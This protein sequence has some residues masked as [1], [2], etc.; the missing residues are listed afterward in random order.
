[1]QRLSTVYWYV[2]W[3]SGSRSAT[4]RSMDGN[5]LH[6]NL[7]L[8]C[9]KTVREAGPRYSPA[10]AHGSPN[11]K[12]TELTQ[13]LSGA[14]LSEQFRDRLRAFADLIAVAPPGRSTGARKANAD[15]RRQNVIADALQSAAGSLDLDAACN[16]LTDAESEL[17]IALDSLSADR[18][19]LQ[20]RKQKLEEDGSESPSGE[21]YSSSLES[22]RHRLQA[23]DKAY[24]K[25]ARIQDFIESMEVLSARDAKP[26]LLRGQWGTGKTHFLCDFAIS[27]LSEGVPVAVVLAPALGNTNPIERLA[28][29]LEATSSSEMLNALEARA[30]EAGRRALLLI[31]AINE[32]D[33]KV[34]SVHLKVLLRSLEDRRYI[35]LVVSCRTPY[36]DYI[37]DS[38]TRK[39]L[40]SITHPGFQAQEFD[41]QLEFF[42]FYNLPVLNV[43]L[44]PVEFSRPLFLKL[45]C[46][47][48]VRQGTRTQRIR[49]HALSSGQR[50]MTYVLENFVGSVGQ[51][52]EADHHLEK[53]ACWY[54]LKGH[55]SRRAQ[56]IAGRMA[57][58]EREWLSVQDVL[59]ETCLQLAVD[60]SVAN[61]IVR[62][63]LGAGLLV[64]QMR[65]NGDTYDDV[66]LMPYQRFSDHLISRHLLSSHLDASTQQTITASFKASSRLGKV[67]KVDPR[68]QSYAEPGIA[69][70]LMVEF[71]ERVKRLKA[72]SELIAY[73]PRESRLISPFRRAFMD[74]LYW[75]NSSSFSLLSQKVLLSLLNTSDPF[76]QGEM[77]ET[78]VGLAARP[79]HPWNAD[80]LCSLLGSYDLP[81]RD[82]VWSE[83]IRCRDDEGTINRLM[84][85][86]ER[87]SSL[88]ADVSTTENLLKLLMLLTT[89]T[90]RGL[91][92]RV[93]RAMVIFGELNPSG[94]FSLVP[95][96]VGA[97]DP[98][99]TERVLAAAYGVAMR[100]WSD[101]DRPAEFDSVFAGLAKFLER[102]VLAEN[103]PS[104][105]WHELS[106]EYAEGVVELFYRQVS[107]S[108]DCKALIGRAPL[109]SEIPFADVAHLDVGLVEE[110]EHTIHMDFGNYTIGRLV[111]E[112]GNYDMNHAEYVTTRK[113][114]AER[115][116]KLGYRNSLFGDVDQF[117]ASFYSSSGEGEKV[118]RYGK[119]YSWIAYF[120]MYAVRGRRQLLDDYPVRRPRPTDVDIDPSFPQ[121]PREAAHIKPF[122]FSTLPIS[123]IEWLESDAKP[124]VA[125]LL[126]E[127]VI[128]GVVGP[129]ALLDASVREISAD[130]RE[131]QYSI[132]S[133]FVPARFVA[134]FEL[135]FRQAGSASRIGDDAGSDYYTFLG[136]V[137]WSIRFGSDIRDDAGVPAAVADRAFQRFNKGRWTDGVPVESTIRR[138][139]WE[140]HH[141]ALNQVAPLALPSP[142][143]STYLNLRN[144]R[145]SAGLVDDMCRLASINCVDRG[146]TSRYSY[147][148]I[149]LL[150]TFLDANDMRM[151]SVIQGERTLAGGYFDEGLSPSLQE[152]Y[153]EGRNDLVRSAHWF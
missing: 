26:I 120:E 48:L 39:R 144:A 60:E 10:V 104:G 92:D 21:P 6:R 55:P 121:E 56:G 5:Q 23:L 152:I 105:T 99:I 72:A 133:L 124:D 54:L 143:L 149:D 90:D 89:T 36:D 22:V 68:S 141:S 98:Y 16:F 78:L 150:E 130:G 47:G 43:P 110:G 27:A 3:S 107:S 113:Q 132:S 35:S 138:W 4:V 38:E 116:A 139:A 2:A 118:D 82:L 64:E 137:P 51:Q 61:A 41:A 119:K 19:I 74:G 59:D 28:E 25:H 100:S 24:S 49:L 114:I 151:V 115:I 125:V 122:E 79:D 96:A 111:D 57:E 84:S 134:D 91:R 106:R 17:A 71:P 86:C 62:D 50:G 131:L 33:R 73:L 77:F 8:L 65:W 11:I 146:G 140:G 109:A 45:L 69:E 147:L 66:I 97:N 12:I 67:F 87:P 94:L 142:R 31:D 129:W 30:K 136:E 108:I 75:R 93:T 126:E 85:W 7:Q 88:A 46:E 80:F 81:K 112:R 53:M 58:T 148:R 70:A 95:W 44:L 123:P 13:V 145:G 63:M 52:I 14:C 102:E 153:I 42:E 18:K 83:F 9:E 37:I 29:L 103:A 76:G 34:W 20:E 135:E 128:D 40:R 1:M 101:A 15:E 127:K 117:I 32:A